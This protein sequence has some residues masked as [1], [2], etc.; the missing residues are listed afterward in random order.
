MTSPQR[1][2]EELSVRPYQPADTTALLGL[3]AEHSEYEGYPPPSRDLVD[4]LPALLSNGTIECWVLQAGSDDLVGYATGTEDHA[5]FTGR[6][7]GH[8]DCLF[9]R[10]SFRGRRGGQM[11][12][13]AVREWSVLREH[14]ELQWQTPDWN[15]RAHA[16]YRRQGATS[17]RKE[18]FTLG[19]SG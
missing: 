9:V 6:A 18:R 19:H 7:F 5:T 16:F 17:R 8:L 14:A 10:D 15:V 12:F 11:L 3:I 1:I 4:H 2:G 13:D